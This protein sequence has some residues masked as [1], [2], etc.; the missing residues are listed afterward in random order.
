MATS[1]KKILGK[2]GIPPSERRSR[3]SSPSFG[4]LSFPVPAAQILDIPR[5]RGVWE[6]WHRSG[7]TDRPW[8]L[9]VYLEIMSHFLHEGLIDWDGMERM[10]PVVRV[11]LER[12]RA[13]EMTLDEIQSSIDRSWRDHMG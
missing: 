12:V 9:G 11:V 6:D 3:S 10:K 7:V 2:L 8:N 5:I 4:G 1:K 13:G